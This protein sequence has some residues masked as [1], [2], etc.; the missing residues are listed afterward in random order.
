[1]A[2]FFNRLGQLGL[3][4]A[5]TGSVVNSALYNVDG[6]HRAV[7]FDR[8]AGIKNL[9]VGE[10]THFY[11]PWIQKPI[12]FDIR[13]RPRNVPV[14]TGSKDLQNVNITLRIL[15]RP[16]PDQLPKIYTILGVDYDE[17]VL[18]SIT[19]EVLKAVVAQF[20]AGEL[21]TQR[22]LVSQK[23][24]EDLT[25]RASQFGVILDD[26]SITHLTF[27]KEFTQ[28]V[29]L[30]QVAQQEAEKARFL[31]ERAEQQKKAAIISAEG[32]AQAASLIAKSLT[33]AGDGLVEL[34]RIEA[35]EDI[36]YQLSRSRQIS[37]L[38]SG[39]GILLNLPQ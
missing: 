12:I 20:D 11:I 25:E 22:E 27:G 2:G 7:I 31:V 34:R 8:F 26:I 3:G 39:P 21:I 36:A 19:T 23:V 5:L 29:E 32:D 35:A 6:G 17:R 38:P 30:K 18:P 33:E 24:S 13:S 4:I 28:A 37:Y 1:M 16:K 9:V 14:V 15:F 10:G